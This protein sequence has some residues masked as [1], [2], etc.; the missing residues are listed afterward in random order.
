MIYLGLAALAIAVVSLGIAFT[1]EG[2]MTEIP[3]PIES[4]VPTPGSSVIRQTSVEIDLEFGHE[5]TIFVDGFALPENELVHVDATGVYRWA[6]S[7]ASNVMAEW[8]P[9]EHAVRV[10]WVRI[11][12]SPISGTFEWS[13]RVQ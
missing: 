10:E 5:A 12:D 13:F 2:E 6:P 7:P 8:E 11:V 3:A 4:V 9:G 1:P